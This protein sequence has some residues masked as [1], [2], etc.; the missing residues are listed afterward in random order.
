MLNAKKGFTL[1]ELLVSLAVLG[2]IAAFAV[3]KVLTTVGNSTLLA[4]T[5][6]AMSTIS[7]A[8]ESLKADS[9]GVIPTSFG[10]NMT[11]GIPSKMSY[12]QS[13]T[14]TKQNDGL[15]DTFTVAAF[16]ATAGAYAVRFANG[17]ILAFNTGDTFM[18][19]TGT[20]IGRVVFSVDSD[21]TGPN[22]PV[23]VVLG[24]D[25]R[26]FLPATAPSST[27]FTVAPF[28]NYVAAGTGDSEL[29]VTLP[30]EFAPFIA[31]GMVTTVT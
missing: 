22:K 20:Q 21:G 23:P 10:L 5:K 18:G 26:I 8:Y 15:A 29:T 12:N 4:N 2:L 11:T 27:A 6:E 16:P 31:A 28:S 3:P 14:Y 13:G 9:N 25:G 19:T 17:A 1:S 7:G 30:T 24:Y